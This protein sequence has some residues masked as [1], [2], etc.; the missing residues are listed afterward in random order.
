[1]RGGFPISW[2]WWHP[3]VILATGELKSGGSQVVSQPGKVT[4]SQKQNTN[5]RA[6]LGLK[7]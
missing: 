1:M 2:V 7:W 5:K 4:L 3:S 6:G